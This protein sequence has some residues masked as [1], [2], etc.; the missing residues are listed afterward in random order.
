MMTE[1]EDVED[2]NKKNKE[3]TEI[4]ELADVTDC[5]S[6]SFCC[7]TTTTEEGRCLARKKLKG[8][9]KSETHTHKEIK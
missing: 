7:V 2:E 5:V 6:L 3:V 8:K 9:N 4:E 1:K